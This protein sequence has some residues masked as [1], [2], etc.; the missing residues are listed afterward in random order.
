MANFEAINLFWDEILDNKDAL[1]ELNMRISLKIR[2]L[3]KDLFFLDI[4]SDFDET[5][6]KSFSHKPQVSV[7]L[8]AMCTINP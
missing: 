4:K 1:L 6:R 5:K 2:K 8:V 3:S 7:K